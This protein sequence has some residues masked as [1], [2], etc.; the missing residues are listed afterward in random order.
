MRMGL[1]SPLT[2]RWWIEVRPRPSI[3]Q[4]SL[5]VTSSGCGTGVGRCSAMWLSGVRVSWLTWSCLL[6]FAVCRV[7]EVNAE[8]HTRPPTGPHTPPLTPE[9]F[10]AWA[11]HHSCVH[12]GDFLGSASTK[13]QGDSVLGGTVSDR[14]DSAAAPSGVRSGLGSA[15]PM[16]GETTSQPGSVDRDGT[17]LSRCRAGAA[18]GAGDTPVTPPSRA[19][20]AGRAFLDLQRLARDS[21]RPVQELLQ[22]YLL[23]GCSCSCCWR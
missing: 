9:D 10:L 5:T 1:S 23:E 14:H 17:E 3:W 20:T 8:Q 15:A 7:V 11:A 22:L 21:G 2:I 6:G 12:M 4:A 18:C 13:I 19:T 16:V